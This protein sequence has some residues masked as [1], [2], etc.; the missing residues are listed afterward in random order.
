[1][2]LGSD[3][4]GKASPPGACVSNEVSGEWQ[5]KPVKAICLPPGPLTFPPS[6]FGPQIVQK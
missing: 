4:L 6:S 3:G 1:M 2:C 5:G